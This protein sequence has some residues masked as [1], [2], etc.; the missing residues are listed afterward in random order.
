M[1]VSEY[2]LVTAP[3]GSSDAIFAVIPPRC[4]FTPATMMCF[5]VSSQA[6]SGACGLNTSVIFSTSPLLNECNLVNFFKCRRTGEDLRE[7]RFAKRRHSLIKGG[8]LDFGSG[9]SFGDH[10][11]NVVGKVEEFV[12]RSAAAKSSTIA[13]QTTLAFIEGEIAVLIQIQTGLEQ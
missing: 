9:P 2:E 5:E 3:A 4:R 11:A 7:R 1:F 13:F 8:A 12:N 6:H 10:F